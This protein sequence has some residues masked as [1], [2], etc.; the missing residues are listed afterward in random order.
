MKK[1]LCLLAILSLMAVSA[2]N[3]SGSADTGYQKSSIHEDFPV[4]K[5]AKPTTIQFDNPKI[6]KGVKYILQGIGGKQGLY[7]PKNYFEEIGKWGWEELKDKQMGHVH[8]FRKGKT[9][10]SLVIHEDY[11]ALYKMK[12][13]FLP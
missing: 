5:N 13:P 12:E 8:F 11:F 10:I 1:F 7:P 9:I 6:E 3:P 2:C 4:P